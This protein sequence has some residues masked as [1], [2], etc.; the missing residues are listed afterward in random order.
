MAV[1]IENSMWFAGSHSYNLIEWRFRLFELTMVLLP[2][3][4]P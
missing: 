1:N 3:E 4:F 2:A